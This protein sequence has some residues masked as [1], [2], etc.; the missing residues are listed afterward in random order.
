MVADEEGALFKRAALLLSERNG[1]DGR[2]LETVSSRWRIE[3]P[4]CV[5]LEVD[6]D[7]DVA[8]GDQNVDD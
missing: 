7:T 5:G 4:G 1:V 6:S 2:L 3:R 8:L